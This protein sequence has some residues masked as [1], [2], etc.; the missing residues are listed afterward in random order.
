V[1]YGAVLRSLSTLEEFGRKEID[2]VKLVL[3]RRVKTRKNLSTLDNVT[4]PSQDQAVVFL[5]NGF[6]YFEY[7][8]WSGF[9]HFEYSNA[10]NFW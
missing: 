10:F 2:V 5:W 3:T 9:L 1:I 7:F 6:L 8:L 4:F